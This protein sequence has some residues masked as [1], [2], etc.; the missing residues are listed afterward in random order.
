MI[1]D[2][3]I[4]KNPIYTSEQYFKNESSILNPL[5]DYDT[6]MLFFYAKGDSSIYNFEI[7]KNTKLLQCSRYSNALSKGCCLVGRKVLRKNEGEVNRV[8]QLTKEGVTPI[9]YKIDK[10]A[11]ERETTPNKFKSSDSQP[12]VNARTRRIETAIRNEYPN[13]LKEHH[14]QRPP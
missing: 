10:K 11:F 8:L 13:W 7:Y 12:V 1:R 2:K 14:Q 3:R 5:Y 4:F 9:S 6:E